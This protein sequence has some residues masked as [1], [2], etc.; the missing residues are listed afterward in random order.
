V[1]FRVLGPL[2]VHEGDR[3]LDLGSPRERALLALLLLHAN[4]V[5]PQERIVE[6]LWPDGAPASAAK[7]VQIYVS[8]LR[9]AFGDA[10]D[11]LESRGCGY[12]LRVD[13]EDVDLHR[14][15]QLVERAVREDPATKAETLRAA[16]GLWRD[17]PLAE[18][19]YETFVQAERARLEELRLLALEER[20]DAELADGGGRELVPE[21]EALVAEHPLRERLRGQLMLALYRAGRQADAL[22]TFREARQLL[23]DELGL[24]PDEQLRELERAILRQDPSLS[25]ASAPQAPRS[26]VALSDSAPAVAALVS[27]A[28]ALAARPF[29][30]QLVL[31]QIVASTELADSTAA[32]E[33]LRRPLLDRGVAARIAAFT[34]STPGGDAA[35]LA[36]QQDADLLL[37]SA[38]DDPFA[39]SFGAAF[40]ETTCDVAVL[41]ERAGPLREGPVIVPFGALEHDWGALELGAWAAIAL[42]RPLQLIGATDGASD[43]ANPSRLLA[44]ASL[45]VQHTAGVVAEPLLGTGGAVGIADLASNAGLL[46]LGVSE[47]WRTEGLGETRAALAAEP[48][49]PMVL[50][51]RG[52]RPSGL[53]PNET[54]TRFTWSIARSSELAP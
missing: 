8:R 20:T 52:L 3:Q 31:A 5:L 10:R 38:A 11:V 15:E 36:R 21:L 49:A 23:D 6:E 35:R 37:L 39:G 18:F 14:F 45:I 24:E 43:T 9:K 51:R 30:R 27:L 47:R 7:I 40:T 48:P 13:P 50:V 28:S 29:P 17:T 2:E 32:L 25:P 42:E 19:G 54:L 22:A 34:S 41:V 1:Q 46:V 53:A 12:V 33:G 44:D 26:I 16:L 4:H